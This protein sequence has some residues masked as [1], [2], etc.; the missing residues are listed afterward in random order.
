MWNLFQRHKK[1]IPKY[2][3][4]WI[5]YSGKLPLHAEFIR[6]HITPGITADYDRWLQQAYGE[7]QKQKTQASLLQE[8]PTHY[9]VQY[10]TVEQPLPI[11]GMLTTSQ[12]LS[13]RVYP[14][15]LIRI[16][17][18]PLAREFRTVIP[19]LYEETFLQLTQIMS[20]DWKQTNL[21]NIQQQM[22]NL[23]YCNS[24]MTRRDA[25]EMVVAQLNQINVGQWF[26]D[27]NLV[28]HPL[29]VKQLIEKL[30]N[31]EIIGLRLPLPNQL[32]LLPVVVFWLQLLETCLDDKQSS[33]NFYWHGA[34]A[35]HRAALHF[36][37]HPMPAKYFV[38][39][40]DQ[41]LIL[42]D[43]G[44]L[45]SRGTMHRAPAQDEIEERQIPL[46]KLLPRWCKFIL[47]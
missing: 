28:I 23:R 38:N 41:N 47:E 2:T 6:Y 13:E 44:D 42:P 32:A 31:K 24:Q 29:D 12:D 4:D 5:A 35:H 22:D 20:C 39:C 21:A 8:L 46:I 27:M 26:D 33:W 43:V 10:G 11:L 45:L 3:R 19:L 9:F 1:A 40:V 34:G 16:L 7:W 14:F 17:E 36:Y 25:L 37:V 15:S 18:H 30:K